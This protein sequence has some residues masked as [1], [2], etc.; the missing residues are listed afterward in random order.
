MRTCT[1]LNLRPPYDS[2][3]FAYLGLIFY[4]QRQHRQVFSLHCFAEYLMRCAVVQPLQIR[5]TH[6]P[7]QC[8][9]HAGTKF[10]LQCVRVCCARVHQRPPGMFA[11]DPHL[12][13]S[14][15]AQCH[16]TALLT[17]DGHQQPVSPRSAGLVFGTLQPKHNTLPSDPQRPTPRA[18]QASSTRQLIADSTNIPTTMHRC[19]CTYSVCVCVCV[20]CAFV[21]VGS[22]GVSSNKAVFN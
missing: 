15:R 19:I 17:A 20:V 13:C 11:I 16:R 4:H 21:G 5:S 1:E 18:V 7:C 12:M 3:V 14:G 10:P 8:I 22:S 6:V 2:I 9:N